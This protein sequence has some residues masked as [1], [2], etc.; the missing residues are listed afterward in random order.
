LFSHPGF[1]SGGG[2]GFGNS[3]LMGGGLPVEETVV[4]NYYD[5]PGAGEHHHEANQ[6]ADVSEDT[7]VPD[8]DN[9]DND[10]Q[11]QDADYDDS[12]DDS[13]SFDDSS[14]V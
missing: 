13:S 9:G 2:L 4:N 3:G 12:N 10:V 7:S 11:T 14:D 1:G 8:D 5:S 6:L